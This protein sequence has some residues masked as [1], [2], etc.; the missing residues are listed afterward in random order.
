MTKVKLISTIAAL[1]RV[2]RHFDAGDIAVGR[3]ALR[4]VIDKLETVM[5][6]NLK[7]KLEKR[8]RKRQ[9]RLAEK[10]KETDE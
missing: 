10:M 1:R 6:D 4:E 3:K 2:S 8:N 9:E 5:N 7:K